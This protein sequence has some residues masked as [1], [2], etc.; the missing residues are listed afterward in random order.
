[1]NIFEVKPST[2]DG[3]KSL[4]KKIKRDLGIPHHEALDLSAHEAGFQNFRH[5][6]QLGGH[7]PNYQTIYLSA[8]WYGSEGAGRETLTLQIAKPLYEIASRS[9]LEHGKHL[10]PFLLEFADHLEHRVDLDCQSEAHDKIYAA[11][12]SIMFMDILSLRPAMRA[13]QSELLSEYNDLPGKDHSSLWAHKQTGA[14]VFMDEPYNPQFRERT[15]WASAHDIHML[16]SEW[17][18]IYRPGHS[19]PNIFCRDQSTMTLLQEQAPRLERGACEI[20]GDMESAPYQTQFI[21]PSREAASKKRRPRPMPAIPGLEVKG[22]L[23]YGQ[24]IGGLT[25]LWRP[26]KRITLDRHLEIASLLTSLGYSRM[27]H[28]CESPFADVRLA[29]DEWM[30]LEFPSDEEITD[31]QRSAY[32]YNATPIKIRKGIEQL[33]AINKISDLLQQGYADCKPLHVVLKKLRRMHTAIS[34]KL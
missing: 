19:I 31:E 3:I 14:V 8:Y 34:R 23:P 27:P 2:L 20:H 28:A 7:N 10:R 32:S 1:M 33:D 18:G 9:Q 30:N 25:S 24:F 29:L 21:S 13:E 26:A 12:R 16:S 6:Q 5:A 15:A 17:R 22:A 11:A 4:A